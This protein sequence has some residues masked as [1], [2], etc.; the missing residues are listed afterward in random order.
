[1]RCSTEVFV[2]VEDAAEHARA[3]LTLQRT[4]GAEIPH[5]RVRDVGYLSLIIAGSCRLLTGDVCKKIGEALAW[6]VK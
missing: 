3:Q 6:H 1:M 4:V 2:L 5:R